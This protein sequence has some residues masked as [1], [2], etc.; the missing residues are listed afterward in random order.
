MKINTLIFTVLFL[1]VFSACKKGDLAE[2]Q[3]TKMKLIEKLDKL[4]VPE[5][6][7]NSTNTNAQ[8]AVG[9]VDQVKGVSSYFSYFDIPEDATHSNASLGD[10]EYYWNYGGMELWESYS[11]TSSTYVWEIDTDMGSGRNK[12]LYSEENKDGNYGFMEVYDYASG[13]E[14]YI[15]KYEWSFD[16]DGNATLLW[17]AAD[18]SFTYEVTSNLDSSGSAEWYSNGTLLYSFVWNADGS[19]SYTYYDE[20]GNEIMSDSWSASDL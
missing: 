15:F 17:E 6:M 19:G 7:K 9:Y 10:D 1:L 12:Y 18:K 14:E 4:N 3:A 20:S 8:Q 16:N 2:K 5:N 13:S 11:E